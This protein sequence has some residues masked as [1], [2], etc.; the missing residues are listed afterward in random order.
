MNGENKIDY[1]EMPAKDPAVAWAFF[2]G[3]FGWKFDDYGP[4]YNAFHDGRM[5]GGFY[6]S[7]KTASVDNGSV[8]VVFYLQDLE[9]GC[10]RVIELGGTISKDIFEFPGGKR[11]HFTDPNGNE[12][13]VWSDK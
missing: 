5:A 8:L 3:L 7:D 9:A 13:A 6:R 12:Y 1:I 11:F 10:R 2:E 4:D